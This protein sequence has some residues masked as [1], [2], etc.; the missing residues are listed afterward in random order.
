[1]ATVEILVFEVGDGVFG[2]DIAN[3]IEITTATEV[4]PVPA[5]PDVVDGVCSSRGTIITV[6]DLFKVLHKEHEQTEHSMFVTCNYA[7]V[8]AAFRTGTV[9]GIQRTEEDSVIPP[10]AMLNGESSSDSLLK[11]VVPTETENILM[12]DLARVLDRLGL[13]DT[14]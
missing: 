10:P 6:I 2:V 14:N 13:T 1:M 12:L 9:R 4:T 5:S 3:V 11:G 8:T 7:G